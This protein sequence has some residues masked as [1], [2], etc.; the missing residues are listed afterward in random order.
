MMLMAAPP[1]RCCFADACRAMLRVAQRHYMS[2]DAAATLR[3]SDA[4]S[5]TPRALHY[6]MFCRHFTGCR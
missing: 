3:L 1:R 4:D 2:T 5:A 6:A